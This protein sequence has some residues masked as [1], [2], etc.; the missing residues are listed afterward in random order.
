M[1]PPARLQAAIE[2]LDG[3]LAAARDGGAAADSILQAYLRSRRFI[4]AKDRAAIRD[5]VWAAIRHSGER[6]VS[7]RAALLGYLLASAPEALSSFDGSDHAPHPVEEGEPQTPATAAPAW[8]LPVLEARF[9]NDLPQALAA[10]SARAPLDIRV[11]RLTG[12][13]RA[14]VA[15]RLPCAAEP[16]HVAGLTLADALRLPAGTRL[17]GHPLRKTGAIEVQDAGSQAVVELA[18]ARPGM[19]VVDLC[20]GAGG[21]SLALASA[22]GG[23][24]R[25]LA[26][27]TDRSRLA[28]LAPRARRAGALGMIETRLLDPGREATQL[29]DWAGQ[30]DVVL[31]DA[32]CSGTGTWRRNPELRWRLTPF[33]L[34]RLWALQARLLRLGAALVR[35]GGRLIYAVCSV[36]DSEGP[37]II[38]AW[39]RETGIAPARTLALSPHIHGCDGFFIATFEMPC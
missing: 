10:L 24:G 23:A 9:G 17:E 2:V 15:A 32:P 20:A 1:R 18:G 16:V 27:D 29:A 36:L 28:A 12:M 11:N 39:H 21:K 4:G 19:A 31:I 35:P 30:A 25:I 13:T 14:Q 34:E 5:L 6:P 8:L 7:G 26:T 38:R 33:R 3:V 22:L 37:D